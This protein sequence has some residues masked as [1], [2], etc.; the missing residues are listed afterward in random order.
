M[1]ITQF[2]VSQLSQ[3]DSE[4]RYQYFVEQVAFN[5]EVWILSDDDG[6]VMLNTEDEE[7]VPVWPNQETAQAWA[8][9]DWDQCEPQAIDLKSWQLRWTAGLE[10][11]GFYVV[12]L[13]IET[14]EGTVVEPQELE[15]N[16]RK[17]IKRL[18]KK[19]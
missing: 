7:C 8:T 13:P 3:L 18:N 16:L 6:C 4:Q 5:K 15:A 11:D 10:E 1:S 19:K 12:V 9:G 14:N 17:E 2:S